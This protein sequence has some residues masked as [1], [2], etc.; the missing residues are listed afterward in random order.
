MRTGRR[1]WLWAVTFLVIIG[2]VIAVIFMVL[3]GGSD[4]PEPDEPAIAGIECDRGERD[5]YHVHPQL[6]VYVEGQLVTITNNIGVIPVEEGDRVECLY[7]LHT[8]NAQ[9]GTIHVEAPREDN[10]TLGQFFA[11]WGQP[12]SSTQL[13]D[14]TIDAE[15]SIR[16]TVNGEL[17]DGN[18]ADI[19]LLD[20]NVIILEYGPPFAES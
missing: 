15:R 2:A 8:H 4:G 9:T 14:R 10:Y 12:L 13:L 16:A 19:P 3:T 1:D 20:K 7:W 17:Y 6:I 11:I 18:P 5:D